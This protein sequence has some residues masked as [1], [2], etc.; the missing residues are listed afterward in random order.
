[1]ARLK[2]KSYDRAR[3]LEATRW[4]DAYTIWYTVLLLGLLVQKN[5]IINMCFMRHIFNFPTAQHLL[6][7]GI[8]VTQFRSYIMVCY[9]R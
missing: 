4:V 7:S 5:F 2:S 8:A 1:M 9:T 3:V 6:T